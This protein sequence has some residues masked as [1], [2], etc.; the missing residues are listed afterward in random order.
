MKTKNQIR[1]LDRQWL[2][3]EALFLT[4]ADLWSLGLN[5]DCLLKPLGWTI[6]CLW[7]LEQYAF[8]S[9]LL[10]NGCLVKPYTG[11]WY[12]YEAFV[13]VFSTHCDCPATVHLIYT[14]ENGSVQLKNG[15]IQHKSKL[16]LITFL[17]FPGT[18]F[19]LLTSSLHG[20]WFKTY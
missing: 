2:P 12:P 15:L 9:F 7:N 5:N 11:Q 13:T 10:D 6:A 16:C 17:N 8:W 20:V 1:P 18:S 14:R 4:M 19:F 3:S